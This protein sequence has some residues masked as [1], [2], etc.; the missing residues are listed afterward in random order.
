MYLY[1]QTQ[2]LIFSCFFYSHIQ[3]GQLPWTVCKEI[4]H[5]A[6]HLK[7]SVKVSIMA[8]HYTLHLRQRLIEGFSCAAS[9]AIDPIIQK[10]DSDPIILMSQH[11]RS[12]VTFYNQLQRDMTCPPSFGSRCSLADGRLA[13]HFHRP[14][15]R[16]SS[17][18]KST[19]HRCPGCKAGS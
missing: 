17:T 1:F 6:G 11:Q 9:T 18:R 5:I 19:P 2:V 14:T 3:Q 13:T 15:Y 12:Q 10:S 4:S 8:A 7:P 16:I